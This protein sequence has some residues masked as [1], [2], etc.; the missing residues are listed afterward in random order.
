MTEQENTPQ[1]QQEP[2]PAAHE[3]TAESAA[4]SKAAQF[5]GRL[6]DLY[7]Q[8]LT[9]DGRKAY[10]R[11]GLALFHSLPDEEA[12]A[13]RENLGLTQGDALDHYNTG[14]LL[15][16]R[17]DYAGAVAAFE[18]ALALNPQ[19]REAAYN[20]ALALELSGKTAEARKAWQSWLEQAPDG[21]EAAEVRQHLAEL[22]G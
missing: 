11:W 10:D 16:A 3:A 13:Q 19:M 14:C 7:R 6:V 9:Q 18:R 22:A 21:E 5:H 17:Q 15:A 1:E 2:T 8:A 12:Q 20:K 4:A